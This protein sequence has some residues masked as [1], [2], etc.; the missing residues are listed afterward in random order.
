MCLREYKTNNSFITRAYQLLKEKNFKLAR[1]DKRIIKCKTDT[2]V[3]Y[4]ALNKSD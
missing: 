4:R 3:W 2:D 1:W